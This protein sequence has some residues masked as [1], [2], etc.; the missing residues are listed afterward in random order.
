MYAT[1]EEFIDTHTKSP[2]KGGEG[3]HAVDSSEDERRGDMKAQAPD[4][5]AAMAAGPPGPSAPSDAAPSV[6]RDFPFT[7][8]G[9]GTTKYGSSK[10]DLSLLYRKPHHRCRYRRSRKRVDIANPLL[11]TISAIQDLCESDEYGESVPCYRSQRPHARGYLE[12]DKDSIGYAGSN[13]IDS[14]YKSSCPTPDLS[15]T[16]Y[17]G[18]EG[19]N[20]RGSIASQGS[21]KPRIPMGTK[22]MNRHS[23]PQCPTRGIAGAG[24]MLGLVSS[25]GAGCDSG[26]LRLGETSYYDVDLDHLMYLRQSI[27][28]AMQRYE[29]VADE[30][31]KQRSCARGLQ[32]GH[33]ASPTAPSFPALGTAARQRSKSPLELGFRPRSASASSRT[34]SSPGSPKRSS[35]GYRSASPGGTGSSPLAQRRS[36]SPLC[37]GRGVPLSN[38]RTESS[39]VHGRASY[40]ASRTHSPCYSSASNGSGKSSPGYQRGIACRLGSHRLEM[41]GSAPMKGLGAVPRSLMSAPVP[42]SIG[43]SP[44]EPTLEEDIDTLL[45]G[46]SEFRELDNREEFPCSYVTMIEDKYRRSSLAR[47]KKLREKRVPPESSSGSDS[48][49]PPPRRQ[50]AAS[51]QQS[52]RFSEVAKCMLEIIE[53]LQTQQGQPGAVAAAAAAP[54]GAPREAA[55]RRPSPG[56]PPAPAPAEPVP[57]DAGAGQ[58][59]PPRAIEGP[60]RP[61][62]MPPGEYHVYEEILYELTSPKEEATPPPPLPKRPSGIFRWKDKSAPR[63]E[64]AP[65][66]DQPALPSASSSPVASAPAA[67]LPPAPAAPQTEG[68]RESE[69]ALAANKPKQ[70]SNL[71]SL[72]SERSARRSISQSLESELKGAE[73]EYGFRVNS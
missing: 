40:P 50:G 21:P 58:E 66:G 59:R 62:Q 61:L 13:S 26:M 33:S 37:S 7:A 46:H 19:G 10:D 72:F 11:E 29:R 41:V 22:V 65:A 48:S 27:L 34:G 5:D 18:Q 60:P 16:N 25:G 32:E 44:D 53:D 15:D 73:D 49:S 55:P 12:G 23:H 3:A 30:A 71:Y 2:D 56:S 39:P 1:F 24:G 63:R 31:G 8:G 14:G 69:T 20:K 42:R 64:V 38:I 28:S 54:R 45:Y 52:T 68:L 9:G 17:Y 43:I 4:A 67:N 70:R 47:V 36:L 35:S 51:A 57:H 6:G